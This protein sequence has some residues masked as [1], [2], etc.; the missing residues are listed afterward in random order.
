MLWTPTHLKMVENCK[1]SCETHWKAIDMFPMLKL[2]QFAF[3]LSN[4][5]SF[6]MRSRTD[7]PGHCPR[8]FHHDKL[9][10][11]PLDE[12]EWL[13]SGS[14]SFHKQLGRNGLGHR[15]LLN[16][17]KLKEELKKCRNENKKH[18]K[19]INL[20]TN[21]IELGSSDVKNRTFFKCFLVNTFH[22]DTKHVIDLK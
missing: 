12:L 5:A 16:G 14:L 11:W 7:F 15:V 19:K 18:G 10:S 21:I 9:P 13:L 8:R 1:I 22:F 2:T 6:L 3:K 4:K 20:S 17:M